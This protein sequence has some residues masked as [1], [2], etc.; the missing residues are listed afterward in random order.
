MNGFRNC[1]T[2]GLAEVTSVGAI[3]SDILL[4]ARAR[5]SKRMYFGSY[6]VLLKEVLAWVNS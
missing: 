3:G 2:L 5:E 4:N 6:E 1:S